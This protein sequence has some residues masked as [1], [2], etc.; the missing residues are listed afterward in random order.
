MFAY[1]ALFSALLSRLTA[2]VCGSTRVTSFMARFLFVFVFVVF[3][4]YPPIWLLRAI[5]RQGLLRDRGKAY[6][7]KFDAYKYNVPTSL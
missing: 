7:P 2:L 1:I 6:H 3:V 5:K 4:E